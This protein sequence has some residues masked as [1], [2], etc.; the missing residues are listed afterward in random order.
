MAAVII[1]QISCQVTRNIQFRVYPPLRLL[2]LLPLL[3]LL[4]LLPLLLLLIGPHHLPAAAADD[5]DDDALL[6]LL[7]Y[8]LLPSYHSSCSSVFSASLTSRAAGVSGRRAAR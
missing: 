3:P 4:V 6:V 5:D 7:P 1:S 8:V 2:P